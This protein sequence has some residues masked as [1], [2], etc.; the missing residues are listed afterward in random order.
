MSRRNRDQSAI[1]LEGTEKSVSHMSRRN[2]VHPA[3]CSRGIEIGQLCSGGKENSLSHV[4]K[5]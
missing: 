4:E 2:R 5:E 3:M 1:F